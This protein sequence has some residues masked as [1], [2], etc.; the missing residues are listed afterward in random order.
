MK[1]T[2]SKEV[3][4]REARGVIIFRSTN[5]DDVI[6]SKRMKHE[7]SNRLQVE[8]EIVSLLLLFNICHSFL[9]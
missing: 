3:K 4:R 2:D 1:A 8:K 7:K 9:T 5:A 6:F